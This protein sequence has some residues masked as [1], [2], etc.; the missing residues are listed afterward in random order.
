MANIEFR[1]N[2]KEWNKIDVEHYRQN[3]GKMFA[4]CDCT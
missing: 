3:I 4:V 1:R 2:T